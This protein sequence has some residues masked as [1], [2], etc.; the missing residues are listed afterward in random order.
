MMIG[1]MVSPKD[2]IEPEIVNGNYKT[3]TGGFMDK[4]NK[5]IFNAFKEESKSRKSGGSQRLF[6]EGRRST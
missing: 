5:K 2:M 1:N 4:R 6:G 3:A